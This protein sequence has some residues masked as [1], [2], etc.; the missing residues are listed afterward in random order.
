MSSTVPAYL[1][2]TLHFFMF[3]LLVLPST[4]FTSARTVTCSGSS[5]FTSSMRTSHRKYNAPSNKC[6]YKEPL[7]YKGKLPLKMSAPP[8]PF[9]LP[10]EYLQLPPGE[11]PD[12][13]DFPESDACCCCNGSYRPVHEE[14]VLPVLLI[15]SAF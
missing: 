14:N 9:H 5:A 13:P 12:F 7:P 6:L 8:L 11:P 4:L 10:P 1:P 2:W 15:Y 3:S